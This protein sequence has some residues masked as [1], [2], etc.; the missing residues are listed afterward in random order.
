MANKEVVE[1][2]RAARLKNISD[3]EIKSNL[4]QAGWEDTD[5]KDA[6]A[7]VDMF[8]KRSPINKS[9]LGVEVA[10]AKPA[11]DPKRWLNAMALVFGYVWLISGLNKI[12]SGEFVTN[13]G[14]SL[15]PDN[16]TIFYRF[17]LRDIILPNADL[18]A[19]AAQFTEAIMGALLILFG[20]VNF[21][22]YSK[23]G[24][25]VLSFTYVV[26][27]GMIANIILTFNIP[28]PWINVTQLFASGVSVEYVILLASGVLATAHFAEF[29][30]DKKQ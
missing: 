24:H 14:A 12:M 16:A 23:F 28:L 8:D 19:N 25:A 26:S 6:I 7:Y 30:H 22:D 10:E 4:K 27:A 13:F 15:N 20:I 3:K 18:F 5:T 11:P 29:F 9:T 21:F 2:V 17:I 1:Y